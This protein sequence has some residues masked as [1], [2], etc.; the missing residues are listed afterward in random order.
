MIQL[1][2]SKNRRSINLLHK[3]A[4]ESFNCYAITQNLFC[5]L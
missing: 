4:L 3:D 2:E 5:N 1:I